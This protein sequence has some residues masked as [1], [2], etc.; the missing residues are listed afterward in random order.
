MSPYRDQD[1]VDIRGELRNIRDEL[2]GLH[3]DIT[4]MGEDV[5]AMRLAADRRQRWAWPSPPSPAVVCFV[6]SAAAM[7]ASIIARAVCP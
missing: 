3:Y 1:P 7:L 4:R 2:R 6:L 5:R